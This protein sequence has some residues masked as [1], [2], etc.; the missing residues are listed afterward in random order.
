M[1]GKLRKDSRLTTSEL[2]LKEANVKEFS[3]FANDGDRQTVFRN[4]ENKWSHKGASYTEKDE[5]DENLQIMIKIKESIKLTDRV[6]RKTFKNE[7]QENTTSCKV[8]N[9]MA[10]LL[11]LK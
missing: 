7:K 5:N 3:L 11:I 9:E 1:D 6:I 10:F 2:K 4:F 8:N